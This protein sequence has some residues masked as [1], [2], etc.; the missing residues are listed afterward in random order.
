MRKLYWM[1]AGFAVVA[2]LGGLMTAGCRS[3]VPERAAIGQDWSA[4]IRESAVG[5][6]L[7]M[8][9]L[10]GPMRWSP[11]LC[12]AQPPPTPIFSRAPEGSPH[13]RKLYH[14]YTDDAA[15]YWRATNGQ[16]QGGVLT[17]VKEAHAPVL[18]DVPL[19]AW[20]LADLYKH[21]RKSLAERRQRDVQGTAISPE[22]GNIYTPGEVISLFVMH[23]VG[24]ADT[25]G[26][27]LGWI[28]GVTGPDGSEVWN[29]GLIESCME[30]H[31]KAPHGR[32]FGLQ[33]VTRSD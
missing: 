29:A 26:T 5:F 19:G 33:Y 6:S 14:L 18:F 21:D 30:C 23:R 31:R 28:Y 8:D 24:D 25:A 20:S 7:T 15:G 3:G 2:G 1:S 17:L 4:Q 32:L 11:Y 22:D 16:D 27:D 12:R 13:S 10:T 9:R